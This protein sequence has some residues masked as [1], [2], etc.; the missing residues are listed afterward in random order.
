MPMTLEN[1]AQA[2]ICQA[3][4]GCGYMVDPVCCGNGA[5]GCDTIGCTGPEADQVTCAA[6]NGSGMVE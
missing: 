6:C 2:H 5:N 3:C 4:G 1:R